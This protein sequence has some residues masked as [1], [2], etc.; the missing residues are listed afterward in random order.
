M[1]TKRKVELAYYV[2][3]TAM[4]SVVFGPSAGIMLGAFIVLM[5]EMVGD[6]D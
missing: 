3:I 2:A 5:L 1:E 6:C 4:L